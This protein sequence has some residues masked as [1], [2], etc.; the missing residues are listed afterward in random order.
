MSDAQQPRMTDTQPPR[1]GHLRDAA[2]GDRRKGPR[3]SIP[4]PSTEELLDLLAAILDALTI[5]PPA[6]SGEDDAAGRARA[7]QEHAK[8]LEHRALLV[9]VALENF[10]RDPDANAAA[11]TAAWLRE[12][13]AIDRGDQ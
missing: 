4:K 12:Q 9:R 10:Q 2:G 8:L 6:T 5:E 13:T 7:V 1:L 11:R 3:V